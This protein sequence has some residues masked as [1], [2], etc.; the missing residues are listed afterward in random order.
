MD[1]PG[2]VV[3]V[4]AA[5]FFVTLIA[6]KFGLVQTELFPQT[7]SRFVR[8]TLRMPTGTALNITNAV[9]K[10]VESR[11][12]RDPRVVDV[13]ASV[14]VGGG[15]GGGQ[16][17]TNQVEP[18]GD[19]ASR[20]Q[21][22]RGRAVR[23]NLAEWIDRTTPGGRARCRRRRGRRCT[24]AG[25]GARSAQFAQFR[26]MIG[27][28][29][30]GLTVFGRTIDIVQ[31]IISQGQDELQIQIFGPDVTKLSQIAQQAIP[32]IAQIPGVT[33]PDTNITASQPLLN[34][35][36][37]RVKA[38]TLGLSTSQ[39]S[40][41]IDTATSGS[42]ASYLQ[43]NGTQYPIMVQLPANQRRTYSSIAGL[44]LA[45]PTSG[46]V[47]SSASTSANGP[48]GG[49]GGSSGL[50]ST[51]NAPAGQSYSLQTVPLSEVAQV[52][53]GSGPSQISRQNKQRE[54]DITASL[55]NTSLG[56]VIG[57]STRVMNSLA[58]PSGY[59]WQYGPAITQQGSTFSSLALIVAL[60]ILLIYMLLAAQFESLLHPLVIMMAVPLA[61]AGVVL[62]LFVTHR[63]FGLTAF[64]G[65]L[66]L[67]GIVVKNAILV[68][69]FTNQLRHEG[70]PARDAVMQAAPLRLRPILMTT[71]ATIGGMTPITIGI[72]AGSSTQAP[73][74]TVVIGGLLCSTLLSLVVIPTLY[75]W[76]ADHIEPRFAPKPTAAPP[77]R[78]SRVPQRGSCSY[79]LKLLQRVVGAQRLVHVHHQIAAEMVA[80]RA[81]LAVRG[82]HDDRAALWNPNVQHAIAE[83]HP[84]VIPRCAH[85]R[86]HPL[87]DAEPKAALVFGTQACNRLAALFGNQLE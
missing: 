37:D 21:Q 85:H 80:L 29:I 66:M 9:T 8:F 71:L 54:I 34:I 55:T 24:A 10:D 19:L 47:Q 51:V 65:V 44:A 2:R 73:L 30:V 87:R 57:Q 78:P 58:L 63:A 70:M 68:V 53:I 82:E 7:N 45:V 18:F 13:G 46:A 22:R 23:A 67:V 75:L 33:R 52:Q 77:E 62:A 28:P 35:N 43:I 31:Q 39:I 3:G 64:I 26:Q 56:A 86:Q 4:A 59:Y 60:A 50:I 40:Q 16:A 38:A 69:E 12:H 25:G 1:H 5:I 49:V 20:D 83:R 76:V 27:R 72:E 6:L 11:L 42:I 36:I 17:V 15:F 48:S 14:G 79:S 61:L 84:F 81:R 74:G 41:A 32:D